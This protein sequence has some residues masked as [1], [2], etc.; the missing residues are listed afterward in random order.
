MC[1]QLLIAPHHSSAAPHSELNRMPMHLT[2]RAQFAN[3]A[4]LFSLGW[5]ARLRAN[6]RAHY[7]RMNTSRVS[8]L[9]SNV[10]KMSFSSADFGN[11][12]NK[13][14][15]KEDFFFLRESCCPIALL[16][17]REWSQLSALLL[18]FLPNASPS[19][20]CSMT[21]APRR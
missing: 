6:E 13:T 7:S 11:R 8:N 19:E 4:K 2:V 12:K 9:E 21:F 17:R 10:R 16:G 14:A 20:P 3:Y 15:L 18:L 1:T 5:S